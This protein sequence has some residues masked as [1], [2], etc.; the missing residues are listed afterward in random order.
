MQDRTAEVPEHL[1]SVLRAHVT[2]LRAYQPRYYPGDVVVFRTISQRLFSPHYPDLGWG[3][4]A[5]HVT[6]QPVP[7]NHATFI[8]EPHVPVLAERLNE[9]LQSAHS[10]QA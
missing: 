9:C 6:V 1:G 10:A 8:Q 5:R 2:A 4:V 3:S 7:G